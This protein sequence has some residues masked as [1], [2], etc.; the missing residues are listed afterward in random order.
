MVKILSHKK[1]EKHTFQW[2]YITSILAT[3]LF[4]AF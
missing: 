1:E 3:G 2:K 4:G